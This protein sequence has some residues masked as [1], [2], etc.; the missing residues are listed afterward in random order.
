MKYR[1]ILGGN[2]GN[3]KVASEP[4]WGWAGRWETA[5]EGFLEEMIPELSSRKGVVIIQE[6]GDEEGRE[7]ASLK[8]SGIFFLWR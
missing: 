6:K 2:D 7:E 8:A 4:H 3:T 5:R 1:D